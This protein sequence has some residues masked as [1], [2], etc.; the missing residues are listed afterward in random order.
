MTVSAKLSSPRIQPSQVPL[1]N[2]YSKNVCRKSLLGTVKYRM[3]SFKAKKRCGGAGP[4]HA[5]MGPMRRTAEELRHAGTS[6]SVPE[7]ALP[8]AEANQLLR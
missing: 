8:C 1:W 2:S 7:G 4:M 3:F 5:T 6:A